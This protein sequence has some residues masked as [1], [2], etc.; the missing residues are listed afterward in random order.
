MAMKIGGDC[1]SCGGCVDECPN[2]AIAE[3]DG[4][5]AIDAAAC[6]EC[7]DS[8]GE[9]QCAS[10]CPADCITQDPAQPET[11]DVLRAKRRRLLAA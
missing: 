9:S 5:Y 7:I 2:M 11:P 3:D 8:F 6:T 10:V 4:L 1:V